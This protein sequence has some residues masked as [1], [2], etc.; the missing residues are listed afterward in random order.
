M[1]SRTADPPTLPWF[2][3]ALGV[4]IAACLVLVYSLGFDLGAVDRQ[5][6]VRRH[7]YRL[8]W[9]ASSLAL[10]MVML[11]CVA[12][13]IHAFRFL[14]AYLSLKRVKRVVLPVMVLAFVAFV[15]FRLLGTVGTGAV[16][17]VYSR[18]PFT[19][20]VAT[21]NNA[22]G[23]LLTMVFTLVACLMMRVPM[24]RSDRRS[25]VQWVAE[26][27]AFGRLLRLLMISAG[28]LI[29]TALFAIHR[30]YVFTAMLSEGRRREEF[31]EF[32]A[33]L[34]LSGGVLFS[35]L[36]AV[37]FLPVAIQLAGWQTRLRL[38][39]LEEA[40]NLDWGEWAKHHAIHSP[41]HAISSYVGLLLPAFSAFATQLVT[42]TEP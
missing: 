36:L 18:F 20:G 29:G 33:A 23:L 32:A 34:A 30:L 6:D 14:D 19:R 25:E 11:W 9:G 3:P 22:T 16:Q 28:T 15:G 12:V 31:E 1:H 42:V 5:V 27:A 38:S 26:L 35:I 39:K 10:N 40:P 2:V 4:A 8:V 7:T 41:L 13:L 24:P 21:I 37:I 17:S